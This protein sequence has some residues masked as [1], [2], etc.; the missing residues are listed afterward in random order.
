MSLGISDPIT[1]W[2][3][4][5]NSSRI[6]SN[7]AFHYFEMQR[8]QSNASSFGFGS[9]QRW[10]I[11]NDNEYHGTFIDRCFY[12]FARKISL[13]KQKTRKE[14]KNYKIYIWRHKFTKEVIS[15]IP[16]AFFD[17]VPAGHRIRF[18]EVRV[19]QCFAYRKPLEPQLQ[20]TNAT[21]GQAQ[22]P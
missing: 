1:V 7:A 13:K 3:F 20:C 17:I 14:V 10:V 9:K 21:P 15:R 19:I 12:Y 6:S 8:K 16:R 11:R 2:T 18:F 5:K 4:S 22:P